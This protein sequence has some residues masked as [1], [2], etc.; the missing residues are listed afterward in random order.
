[1]IKRGL[2]IISILLLIGVKVCNAQVFEPEE[3]GK[4]FTTALFLS[5][6]LPGAGEL[7]LGKTDYAYPFLTAEAGIW[8]S[9]LTFYVRGNWA[10]QDYKSYASD[11]AD[12]NPEGKS[13]Q[14]FQD[15]AFYSS[16]DHYNFEKFL[17]TEDPALL[18]PETDDYYWKWKQES[19]RL[20]YK[21]LYN[22]SEIAQ[23]NV[24]ICLG[25][26]AVSRA[27]S[28]I[29]ILRLKLTGKIEKKFTIEYHPNRLT[30]VYYLD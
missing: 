24:T 14:F 12:V 9:A 28:C 29:N 23:R 6:A 27:L 2:G 5:A 26:A 25:M 3:K 8:I 21:E 10:K 19:E 17:Y 18:Y 4:S 7:Y 11:Y 30:F 20:R 13:D 16:R 15:I 22:R 1:M